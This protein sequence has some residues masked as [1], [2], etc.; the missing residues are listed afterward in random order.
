M[1]AKVYKE[2]VDAWHARRIATLQSDFGWLSVV[3]L[4]WLKEG[5]NA[6]PGFGTLTLQRGKVNLQLSPGQPGTLGEHPFTSGP[7]RTEV[8]LKGPD[9]IKVG[10]KAFVVIKRGDRYAVRIWDTSAE[11]RNRFSGIDRYPVSDRW[12]IE[13]VWEEYRKAK[14]VRL[15]TAIKGYT[16]EYAVPGVAVINLGG[17][18]FRLE[19]IVEEG[20]KQL[21]FVF[22]DQ[23]SG[24]ETFPDGRFLYAPP[25]D[26][27]VVELDFNKA[28]NPPSAFTRFATNPL[29]PPSNRLAIRV[30]AGEKA[31]E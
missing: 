12:K 20:S 24:S 4:Q 19:P 17:D 22:L 14:S 18:V 7:I 30:E 21:F 8:D 29:A 25:P 6:I 9:R 11:T 28:I 5:D 10:T 26:R 3:G 31:Y 16:E 15:P 13:A 1:D 27:G 23:T 2:K